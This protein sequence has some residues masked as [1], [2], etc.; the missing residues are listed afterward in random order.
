MNG[1]FYVPQNLERIFII[2]FKKSIFKEKET[3]VFPDPQEAKFAIKDI[4]E[5]KVDDKYTLSDK[6]WNYLQEHARKH[7]AKG[8]GFGFG[9]CYAR[10]QMYF[11]C[12]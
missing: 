5:T 4:L 3:F 7:K 12:S 2:G 8:N 1:K 11:Y 9:C 6:L 10:L